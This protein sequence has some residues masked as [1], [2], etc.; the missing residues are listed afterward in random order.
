MLVTSSTEKKEKKEEPVPGL[1]RMILLPTPALRLGM[2]YR[3]REKGQKR[4]PL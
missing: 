3:M 4:D 1:S 2:G